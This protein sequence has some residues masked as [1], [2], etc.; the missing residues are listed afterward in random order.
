MSEPNSPAR[1]ARPEPATPEP[2][3]PVTPVTPATPVE[4]VTLEPFGSDSDTGDEG[5]VLPRDGPR[6]FPSDGWEDRVFDQILFDHPNYSAVR[7]LFGN[8]SSDEIDTDTS[9]DE[10]ARTRLDF[11]SDGE[12][13]SEFQGM[14]LEQSPQ[15]PQCV[16]PDEIKAM[17][18]T[19]SDQVEVYDVIAM[20]YKTI[21]QHLEE[22]EEDGEIPDKVI[23]MNQEKTQFLAYD[24]DNISKLINVEPEQGAISGIFYKCKKMMKALSLRP[25]DVEYDRPYFN[26]GNIGYSPGGYVDLLCMIKI[27]QPAFDIDSPPRVFMVVEP[28]TP[29]AIN[30]VANE[31]TI[32]TH[33]YQTTTIEKTIWFDGKPDE[34]HTET[35]YSDGLNSLGMPVD[36]VGSAHCQEG[37][38][39]KLVYLVPVEVTSAEEAVPSAEEAVPSAEGPVP[40]AEEPVSGAEVPRGG[41]RKRK[42]KKTLRKKNLLKKKK[43]KTK[44][45]KSKKGKKSKK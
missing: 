8:H 11:G 39:S 22:V 13:E 2:V 28:E 19:I 38:Y 12:L 17:R 10:S 32:S 33:R 45:K 36:I 27:A 42:G 29:I 43:N 1:P 26:L 31:L 20:E 44:R 6:S 23:F 21:K 35:E 41:K 15:R 34:T 18:P 4:P 37:Q 5:F 7:D 3:E 14:S 40:G 24:R 30:P 25:N 9:A 16:I